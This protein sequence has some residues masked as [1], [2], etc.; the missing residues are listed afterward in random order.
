MQDQKSKIQLKKKKPFDL[1]F[2]YLSIDTPS[3][4][5]KIST[6]FQS[7]LNRLKKDLQAIWLLV[8]WSNISKTESNVFLI[9]VLA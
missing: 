2:E 4:K 6:H 1:D 9:E 3:I 7:L 8:D 5:L